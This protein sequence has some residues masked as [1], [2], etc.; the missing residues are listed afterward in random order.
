MSSNNLATLA[1]LASQFPGVTIK[2]A[3]LVRIADDLLWVRDDEPREYPC[4]RLDLGVNVALAPGD[5]VLALTPDQTGRGVVLGRIASGPAHPE[6]TAV[7]EASQ[8][9][10]LKCGASSIEL[11]ADGKLMVKGED[12]LV[13]ARG[14]QRIK[15]GS[16]NIN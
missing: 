5:T 4:D 7:I 2:R 8:A 11:R 15:A 9:L 12:V 10:T 1:A 14:T 6:A 3:L 16:V 13:K